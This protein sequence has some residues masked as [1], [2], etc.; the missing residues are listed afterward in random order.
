MT[1][2]LSQSDRWLAIAVLKERTIGTERKTVQQ[3]GI[4]PLQ[5]GSPGV[6]TEF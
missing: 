4:Q 2:I 1:I 5:T 3:G 6:Q